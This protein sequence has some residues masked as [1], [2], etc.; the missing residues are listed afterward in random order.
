MAVNLKWIFLFHRGGKGVLMNI[1][2]LYII[3]DLGLDL[4]T[5]FP[6]PGTSRGMGLSG[7]I[8]CILGLSMSTCLV[9]NHLAN[10]LFKDMCGKQLGAHSAFP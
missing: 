2:T 8:V 9:H 5:E 4:W 6:S 3:N 1:A 7:F 10:P